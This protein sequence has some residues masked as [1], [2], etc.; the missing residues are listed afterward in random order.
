MK[1]IVI[2]QRLEECFEY[3]EVR[4][5]L[6][7]NYYKLLVEAGFFP[8]ILPYDI[9]IC[10]YLDKLDI[11]GI[12]LT[13]GNDLYSQNNN[14]LSKK[15]DIFEKKLVEYSII[16]NIPLLGI[17][18]GMQIIAEYFGSTL[19]KVSNHVNKIHKISVNKESVY[20]ENIK[21]LKEVNTFHNYGIE[22]LSEELQISAV[23]EDGIIEALEHRTL[24][25]FGQM[26][27]SERVKPFNKNEINLIQNIFNSK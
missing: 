27:H 11:D 8:I 17:C 1:K 12:L 13:G 21:K 2:T 9:N 7:I 14:I 15:R 19:K 3:S 20:Y 5:S 24:L 25:L 10:E 6:D 26:W 23:S 4:S 16:N 18:R 22:K